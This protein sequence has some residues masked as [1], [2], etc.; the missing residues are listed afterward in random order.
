MRK[1]K[2]FTRGKEASVYARARD[3]R[4]DKETRGIYICIYIGGDAIGRV[5][6]Q[7]AQVHSREREREFS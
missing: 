4:A 7:G 1:Q 6:N 5:E 3:A 2:G